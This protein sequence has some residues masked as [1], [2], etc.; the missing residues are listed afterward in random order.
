MPTRRSHTSRG[1]TETD[2]GRPDAHEAADGGPLQS[3]MRHEV[4]LLFTWANR[5]VR[6]P[7]ILD[8]V[9]SLSPF[10]V[11]GDVVSG[12]QVIRRSMNARGSS[13]K[14][15]SARVMQLGCSAL[16]PT[17]KHRGRRARAASAG[18]D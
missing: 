17:V 13:R 2:R 18:T 3:N 15:A 12:L 14:T 11:A 9:E 16:A 7:K 1:K 4:H 5:L 6:H 10:E 8:A